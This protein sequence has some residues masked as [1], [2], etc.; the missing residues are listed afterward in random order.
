MGQLEFKLDNN[1]DMRDQI[2]FLEKQVLEMRESMDKIRKRLFYE[3]GSVKA[4]CDAL[5]E[6]NNLLR[7]K[8]SRETQ[9]YRP[10]QDIPKQQLLLLV[11]R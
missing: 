5:K 4:L 6:E 1:V 10:S 7:Y 3:L 9:E 11:E 2:F 8:S